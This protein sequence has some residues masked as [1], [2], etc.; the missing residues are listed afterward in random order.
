MKVRFRLLDED[1][2]IEKNGYE[3]V[4]FARSIRENGGTLLV[5]GKAID[6]EHVTQYEL[7][8]V[9]RSFCGG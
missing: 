3:A 8:E 4:I 1:R 5:D 7:V 9:I 6:P 2:V